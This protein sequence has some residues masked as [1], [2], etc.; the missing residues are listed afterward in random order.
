MFNDARHVRLS[1]HR[2][3][4]YQT[5]HSTRTHHTPEV[6]KYRASCH[7]MGA[8]TVTET[9]TGNAYVTE[10]GKSNVNK[11]VHLLSL[12]CR[13]HVHCVCGKEVNE[14]HAEDGSGGPRVLL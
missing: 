13:A 8:E 3:H 5:S 14:M 10:N 6:R 12:P 7:N 2:F 4:R 9:E 11:N 1:F